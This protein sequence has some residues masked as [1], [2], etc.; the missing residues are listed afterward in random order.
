MRRV[1]A[2]TWCS[3]SV[4]GDGSGPPPSSSNIYLLEYKAGLVASWLGRLWE[5]TWMC[6]ENNHTCTCHQTHKCQILKVP[7]KQENTNIGLVYLYLRFNI[8][9]ATLCSGPGLLWAEGGGVTWGLVLTFNWANT[10]WRL[11][12]WSAAWPAPAASSRLGK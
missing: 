10:E 9:R 5:L 12:S 2:A 4:P 8:S 1:L 3:N 7:K 11:I 6:T